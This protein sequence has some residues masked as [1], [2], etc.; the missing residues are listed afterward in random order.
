MKEGLLIEVKRRRVTPYE[1]HGTLLT[2]VYDARVVCWNQGKRLWSQRAG[3]PAIC[4]KHAI[5]NAGYLLNDLLVS[6]GV[7]QGA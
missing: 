7:N 4:R 5:K 3:L 1:Y 2:S 6:G